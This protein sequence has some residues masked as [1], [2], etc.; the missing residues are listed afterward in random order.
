MPKTS[1]YDKTPRLRIEGISNCAWRGYEAVA[2]E[3]KEAVLRH[4]GRKTVLA[5]DCYEGVREREVL[6][7]L[8]NALTPAAVVRTDDAL[9]AAETLENMLRL[10][11]TD[12]RVFGILCHYPIESFFD[13]HRWRQLQE[14]VRDCPDGLVLVY[15][16]G[17]ALLAKPDI[18][19]YADMARWEIQQRF[20]SGELAN[21]CADN[22]GQDP[23]LQYKRSF[24]INWRVLDRHKKD[25]LS[26]LDYLLDTNAR[27]DPKLLA[28]DAL[29]EGWRQA[30]RRPFRL[31]PYFDPGIWGGQWMKAV[32]GLDPEKPNY[33]WCF[34]CVPEENS[35]LFEADGVT[36]ETPA[37]DL[38]FAQPVAL[39]GERVHARFGAEFPIRFDLLDTMGGGNLSLQVH[40]L[41][42]YI[43]DVF[44]MHYTQDESYYILDAEENASIYLGVKEGVKP[45]QLIPALEQAQKTGRFDAERFVN[46]LPA[47]K[48]DHFLIPGGTVHCSGAGTMVLE[49]SAT[50]YIF[51]FKLWDWGRL[52]M[53]G[54]PRPVH[55]GHGAKNIRFERDTAFVRSQLAGQARQVAEG[56]GWTEEVT[57][58]H[59][60]EFIETRRHRFCKTVAHDT[61]VGVNVLNLVEGEE[62]LVESPEG[63][64]APFTV[65][66][67][68]TFI[69]PARVGRYTVTPAGRSAG[70]EIVTIKACVRA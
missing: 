49:I 2:A 69:V 10:H 48:H 68:E 4:G 19:V 29:R 23:Q 26:K 16:T 46:R 42:E 25:L 8:I 15:G 39:L 41:T 53:D 56:D 7:A 6:P 5:V 27:D 28:G 54:R 36:V 66:Y 57:G 38:V 52:G 61:G 1:L 32:C 60:R 45:E 12:D 35:L 21:W 50:P 13:P 59:E 44:G 30:V 64:F 70:R 37:V 11:L 24:F 31:V 20:R 17:A 34:D 67:A 22:R 47:G 58:L 18:L 14:E 62:A 51:T 63:A 3:L 55:I 9:P 43:Q 40:P 33:A 65:H